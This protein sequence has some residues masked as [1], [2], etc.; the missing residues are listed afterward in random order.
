LY[1][2]AWTTETSKTN[3][4]VDGSAGTSDRWIYA[5]GGGIT[6]NSI[7]LERLN[8]SPVPAS[9]CYVKVFGGYLFLAR[10]ASFPSRVWYSGVGDAR[11]W[12]PNAFFD[13]NPDDGDWITGM[14]CFEGRFYLSKVGQLYQIT[15]SAFDPEEGDIGIVP[16]ENVPG[17]VSNR[18][19][20]VTDHGV[21]Y[22]AKDG[23]RIFDGARSV[24]IS[25]PVQPTLDSY[26]DSRNKYV[27]GVWNKQ[28]DEIWWSMTSTGTT[29]DRIVVY[30][31][32]FKRW[33]ITT[34]IGAETISVVEDANDIEQILFGLGAE[35]TGASRNGFIYTA[36]TGDHYVDYINAEVAINSYYQTGWFSPSTILHDNLPSSL[37][38]LMERTSVGSSPAYPTTLTLT[39]MR[40]YSSTAMQTDSIDTSASCQPATPYFQD[41]TDR[42]CRV[43]MA[44]EC[45]GHAMSFKIAN[46]AAS[47]YW[48]IEGAIMVGK[49]GYVSG[50]PA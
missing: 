39:F 21:Y 26:V 18:S 34:G 9:V 32:T 40:D 24:N 23:F 6:V 45:G 50:T 49:D 42:R 46:N 43:P 35:L 8:T 22:L 36:N 19:I 13:V 37:Y 44:G 33:S 20:V 12:D 7:K 10:S 14:F 11:Y 27:C 4:T 17:T 15:G 31:F 3:A 28:D 5:Y 25:E 48:Q 47:R 29:H 2:N 38:L 41:L 1:A 30:N 16:I